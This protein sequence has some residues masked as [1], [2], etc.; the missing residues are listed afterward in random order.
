MD[1]RRSLPVCRLDEIPDGTMKA[2]QVEGREVLLVRKGEHIFAMRDI[3]PH[4]GT[5]L[6]TGSL[7]SATRSSGVGDYRS[8]QCGRIVRCPWHNWEFNAE[9]GRCLHD[10]RIRVATYSV[11]VENGQVSVTV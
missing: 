8:D 9:D 10:P 2:V 5:R 11:Q 7:T 1:S 6:S 4:Q 3:C